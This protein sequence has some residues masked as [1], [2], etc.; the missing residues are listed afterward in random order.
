M[1]INLFSQSVHY[2]N[3]C[4]KFLPRISE[5]VGEKMIAAVVLSIL[6][7]VTIIISGK[8]RKSV[9]KK[10]KTGILDNEMNNV[11]AKKIQKALEEKE[12]KLKTLSQ[13]KIARCWKSYKARLTVCQQQINEK[14][15]P[16]S[17][18]PQ[19]PKK[20]YPVDKKKAENYLEIAFVKHPKGDSYKTVT[21]KAVEAVQYIRMSEFDSALRK[22]VQ[23][24]NTQ[25]TT[26]YAVGLV[27]GKSNQW[28]ASLALK[29]LKLL[30]Q[31]WFPLGS[32]EQGTLNLKVP[33]APFKLDHI[34]EETVALL[35]DCSYSGTQLCNNLIKIIKKIKTSNIPIKK[36][37][38]IIP[39]MTEQAV[40]KVNEIKQTYAS[41]V[42][43]ELI[44]GDKRMKTVKEIIP[45]TDERFLFREVIF[46]SGHLTDECTL[47]YTQWRLP[48][49]RSFVKGFG[50]GGMAIY[51]GEREVK[52]LSNPDD[53]F[54]PSEIPRP[55]EI[56]V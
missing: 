31:N 53:H 9:A 54:V 10:L 22:C 17:A 1:Q 27:E 35:D 40:N 11:N 43:I 28:V 49:G 55:Y 56:K 30:P 36:I 16:L 33:K 23:T 14:L 38:I 37:F 34:T 45:D 3:K 12:K 13:K 20:G 2:A 47:S 15:I 19:R 18:L 4:L 25:L 21:R 46:H 5:N 26:P 39:F 41:S 8:I 24:L 50:A 6:C 29:D 48:D 32:D 44:T 42:D 7:M 51:D 52:N